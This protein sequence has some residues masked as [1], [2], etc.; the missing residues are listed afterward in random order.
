MNPQHKE[1]TVDPVKNKVYEDKTWLANELETKSTRQI[2]KEQRVSY[3]L[4]NVWALN[5]GLIKRS[6]ETIVA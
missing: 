6:E 1:R 2:A 5:Y 4:I 3:K